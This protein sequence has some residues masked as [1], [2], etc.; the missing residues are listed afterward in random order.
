MIRLENLSF[1][2]RESETSVFSGLHFSLKEGE[3]IGICGPNGSGKTTM[4]Q[5]IMG[6]LKPTSG[7]VYVLGKRRAKEEDFFEVRE[8]MGFLF[9]DPDDQLFCLT[10]KE[11][12]AFGPLNLGMNPNDVEKV[13]DETL[14]TLGLTALKDRITYKLSGGE[15]RLVSLATVLAMHPEALILDEPTTGL[16]EETGRKLAALLRQHAS[17]CLVVSHDRSFLQETTDRIYRMEQG[18]IMVAG[19]KLSIG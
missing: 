13:V 5:I 16:E 8:R 18:T 19:P 12:V 7:N 10:V 6:L 11:D 4:L 14:G 17:T 3:R 2:Y 15:K 1:S 9:Q